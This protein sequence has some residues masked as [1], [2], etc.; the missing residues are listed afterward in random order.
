MIGAGN[1]S[2]RVAVVATLLLVLSFAGSARAEAAVSISFESEA[3][4]E[5]ARRIASELTSEGYAANL[6]A[7]AEASPCDATGTRLVS[8]PRGT[9]AWIRVSA[10]P[11][12]PDMVVAS[13][14]YL[15]AQP[16]IQQATPSAPRPEAHELALATAE[17]LNGLRAKLPPIESTPRSTSTT[18]KAE[19]AIDTS[20]TDRP[21]LPSPRRKSL[22]NSL[23]LGGAVVW[24]LP[25]LPGVPGVSARATLGLAPSVGI[26][27]DAFVPVTARE[28]ESGDVTAKVRT[29]WVRVGPRFR[30]EVGDFELSAAALAGPALTWATAVA[31][32][33]RVGTTDVSPGAVL[34]LGV[35][36]EYPR[37]ATVFACASAGASVLLP[38]VEVNLGD[39]AAAP[40]GSFPLEAS[41]GLGARWGEL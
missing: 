31:S 12:N 41:V 2:L 19:R 36:A 32:P 13:I 26:A 10:D 23:V 29:T 37:R 16:F 5:L 38:G 39:P 14:C 18:P 20:E 28:L 22:A 8:V 15:G 34:T 4:L 21:S 17:A 40:R 9:K 27:M 35:T 11:S 1:H 6:S 24:N 25:D 7:T 33:P 30:G 3:E